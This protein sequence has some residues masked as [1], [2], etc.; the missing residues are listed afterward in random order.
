MSFKNQP[1]TSI[2]I[3]PDGNLLAYALGCNFF[4]Y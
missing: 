2:A 1:V 4:Y 3:S